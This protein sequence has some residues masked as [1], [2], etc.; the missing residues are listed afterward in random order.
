MEKVQQLCKEKP[1]AKLNE[2][3]QFLLTLG[4]PHLRLL[5]SLSLWK[6]RG[7]CEAMEREICNPLRCPPSLHSHHQNV[8][9]L[10]SR[11]LRKAVEAV[12]GSEPLVL[13][14]STALQVHLTFQSSTK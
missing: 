2:A 1:E 6:F 3:E 14:L 13:V 8:Q 7:D 10:K 11:E 4:R 12:K 5:E 9:A